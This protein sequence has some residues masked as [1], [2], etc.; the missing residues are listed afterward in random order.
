M[1]INVYRRSIQK[2]SVYFIF[3][4]RQYIHSVCRNVAIMPSKVYV[5]LTNHFYAQ[6]N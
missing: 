2:P 5:T 3:V 6:Y 4:Q 1:Y